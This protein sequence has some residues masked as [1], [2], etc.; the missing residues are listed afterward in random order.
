MPDG[1]GRAAA[2]K[3]E[4]NSDVKD[5]DV[6]PTAESTAVSPG[7][8]A[9]GTPDAPAEET[10]STA[11]APSP[12][13]SST[14]EAEVPAPMEVD[15]ADLP[16][17]TQGSANGGVPD[18]VQA[19][20]GAGPDASSPA[21]LLPA[22]SAQVPPPPPA[23]SDTGEGLTFRVLYGALEHE[24]LCYLL[25]VG[26]ATLLLDCGWD[27]QLD[28][29]LLEPL[30]PVLPQVQLVLLSF[31]DLS[32]MGALPWVAKHLRPGVPIYTTQPVFKMA[33]MVLYDLYLNKCMDTA[34]GAAGCPAFT[35][36]EVDA[37]MARFQL[38]KFSQPLEVRQQG[39]FYLSV[40]PYPAG[41]ILGGCFWRVNYKKMEEIVYAVDFNLKSE[42]H[43]TGAVEAF[44]ALSADKEQRP[45]LFITDAR[46]SPNLSTDERKVEA[47][48]LAAATGTLRKGGHVLIPVE[49]SGRA[50]ELLL[51]LN[52][53]WRSDR[54]LWGYKIVL[55]HHMARNVLHFTKSM[56]EYMHPE[57]IRDFDR[58]LRNPFSLKHVVPAQSMLELEAAMGEYRNPVVVLAS[59]EGMDTGFSRALATRWASGPENALLLC[60]HLRKGSLAESFWK[61][62]H[63]PK[64]ALS[65]SVPVIERI[66]GEELAGLR[67]KEDRERRKA[68]EAEEFRRQAHELMEGTVGAVFSEEQGML[69]G[70]SSNGPLAPLQASSSAK[71]LRKTAAMYRRPRYLVF[72]CR[73]PASVEV[74]A[75][76]E[77]LREGEC[78]DEG[79]AR[80]G[81]QAGTARGLVFQGPGAG[82]GGGGVQRW[83]YLDDVLMT[84]G[85]AQVRAGTGALKFLMRESV[86]EVRWR[87]R[88][89]PME[90]RSDGKN[91]RAILTNLAPRNII[92][93][94]GTPESFTDLTL[95]A[96][97]MLGP[98]TRLWTPPGPGK[99]GQEEQLGELVGVLDGLVG[100][101]AAEGA[102]AA[103]LAAAA[104]AAATE[105]ARTVGIRFESKVTDVSLEEDEGEE[106]WRGEAAPLVLKEMGNYRL[107]LVQAVASEDRVDANGKPLLRCQPV[108]AT[109]GGTGLQDKGSEEESDGAE[110]A[111]SVLSLTRAPL[112][113]ADGDVFLTESSQRQSLRQKLRE[114]GVN[115]DFHVGPEGA[116]LICD[117]TT[118]VRVKDNKVMLEG[119]LSETYFK[120]R[121]AIYS[122]FV[123]L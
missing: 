75:Y 90:G 85:E 79:N 122:R 28:E 23:A 103:S 11:S 69:A 1:A 74:D 111:F 26:E 94:R 81:P 118:V 38:L 61:L 92:F 33:Q 22:V 31:P 62:R 108:V 70:N 4:G 9:R 49:T 63:L 52:R 2:A 53:H 77:P 101:S 89:F 43:L 35:L 84:E 95:H 110:T 97:K 98:S 47:E 82:G 12:E 68:L 113:L 39:R 6:E 13:M 86:V 40:T 106:E 91:L 32:H 42:R 56:V 64:A 50:Q 112:W 29:G 16:S 72:G 66:V 78:V 34:S 119:P 3:N 41:R 17:E 54:L 20:A 59:D 116:S 123:A 96:G 93:V 83:G 10:G 37:A 27:V 45:C 71:R 18:S 51:A 107:A 73:D 14:V 7:D 60:G 65:F 46:P 88:A 19:E 25:K 87:V 99:G 67:E 55:L 121:Q 48:F 57:V 120:V 105:A 36:D 114:A 100:G 44:N 8:A 15:E 30:L 115:P 109:K 117:G 24:P 76:G 104:A 80:G 102:M 21:P 5:L 58:S